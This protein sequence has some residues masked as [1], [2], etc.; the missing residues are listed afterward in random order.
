MGGPTA[1][2]VGFTRSQSLGYV[3]RMAVPPQPTP[4]LS[5]AQVSAQAIHYHQ[6]SLSRGSVVVIRLD[7]DG[8]DKA[9]YLFKEKLLSNVPL[10]AHAYRQGWNMVLVGHRRRPLKNDRAA[11]FAGRTVESRLLHHDPSSPETSNLN[12]LA[13]ALSKELGR[14]VEIDYLKHWLD[15]TSFQ[16][17]EKVGGWITEARSKGPRILFLENDRFWADL[18]TN[19]NAAAER[20]YK[21]DRDTAELDRIGGLYY[22]LGQQVA[23]LGI[24]AYIFDASSAAKQACGSKIC[25]APF[26]PQVAI[27]A[28]VISE[29][30][31]IEGLLGATDYL[32]SGAKFD[33]KFPTAL[34]M[35]REGKI[36]LLIT[37]GPIGFALY[38]IELVY[39]KVIE[40]N[41]LLLGRLG[42][43]H[44]SDDPLYISPSSIE[45]GLGA[46]AELDRQG[47]LNPFGPNGGVV[48]PIDFVLGT[49]PVASS[50]IVSFTRNHGRLLGPKE[51]QWD[52]GPKSIEKMERA[53]AIMIGRAEETNLVNSG[54][55]GRADH[56]SGSYASGSNAIK[57]LNQ[58]LLDAGG[59]VIGIGGEGRQ[60]CPAGGN[61]VIS[62]GAAN[63]FILGQLPPGLRAV[64]PDIFPVVPT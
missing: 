20:A 17:S 9:P 15:P 45:D 23:N 57:G 8:V 38:Y 64:L 46:Y 62:G 39:K 35:I 50:T 34:R 55:P 53:Y 41:D 43:P 47:R 63:L 31:A 33:E 27:G 24:D 36:K 25:F 40:R 19:F 52:I 10:L 4:N 32:L 14:S 58:T 26:V 18:Y 22:T 37:G 5:P 29:L 28:G 11:F 61:R 21:G 42:N 1:R 60:M 3:R 30:E 51:V 2:N 16:L 7:A 44:F 59:N 6:L 56:V 54:M 49:E 13:E 48:N 12:F